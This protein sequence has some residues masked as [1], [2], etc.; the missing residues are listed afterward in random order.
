MNEIGEFDGIS[1][2]EYWSII[3]DHV[4]VSFFSI[5][6]KSKSSGVS[7]SISGSF[8][9]SNSGESKEGWSSLTNSLKE[10]SLSIP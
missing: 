10:R 8:L 4:V 9:S 2:E 3:S 1:N 6:F 5:E 7:S